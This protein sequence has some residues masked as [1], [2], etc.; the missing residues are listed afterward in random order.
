MDYASFSRN[1]QLAYWLNL[2]N[3]TLFEQVALIYP[4]KNLRTTMKGS[5]RRP[6]VLSTKLLVVMGVKI[7][8]DDIM[9]EILIP[10]WQGPL[11]LYGMF[12]GSI[13]GPNINTSA[14][15]GSNVQMLL[16]RNALDF[17]NSI[18]G[19]HGRGKTLQ[20]SEFYQWG[21]AA[22]PDFDVDLMTH[23]LK[24]ADTK[25]QEIIDGTTKIKAGYYDWHVADLY[26]GVSPKDGF[27]NMY[28]SML[29]AGG[30]ANMAVQDSPGALGTV[31]GLS[32]FGSNNGIQIFSAPEAGLPRHTR[33][34]FRALE[35]KFELFG[36]PGTSVTIDEV[37]SETEVEK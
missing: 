6:G 37:E 14:F 26:N 32:L 10:N 28:A 19:V 20:V 2:Y 1:E 8:L 21:A 11:V 23:L 13:G 4:R 33:A 17:V 25:T 35:Q 24:F 27:G 5:R 22:F 12:Q 18:R 34:L 3:V 16:E 29:G 30:V 36:Y 31:T 7:S 9:N 15:T